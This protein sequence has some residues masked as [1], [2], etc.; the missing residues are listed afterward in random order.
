[1]G[2]NA[3]SPLEFGLGYRS[4]W[5]AVTLAG[6]SP[7][8]GHVPMLRTKSLVTDRVSTPKLLCAYTTV[9]IQYL[10]VLSPTT[11]HCAGDRVLTWPSKGGHPCQPPN[12]SPPRGL[13]YT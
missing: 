13:F 4:R 2:S 11:P 3:V 1:M 5:V 10:E 9:L 7:I 12:P 8:A 6:V